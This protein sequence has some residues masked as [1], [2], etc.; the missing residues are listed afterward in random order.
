ME[1]GTCNQ[2]QR[3]VEP[4]TKERGITSSRRGL[5]CHHFCGSG[6]NVAKTG[7]GC[8][9]PRVSPGAIDIGPLQ[10]PC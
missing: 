3:N 1:P 4:G 10:G 9:I 2:E 7:S 5:F 6:K 8:M